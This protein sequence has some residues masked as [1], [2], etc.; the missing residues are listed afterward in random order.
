MDRFRKWLLSGLLAGL[1]ACADLSTQFG[2]RI[3]DPG[4][5]IALGPEE[6]LVVGR[7]RILENGRSKLPYSWGKPIWQLETLGVPDTPHRYLPFLSTREDGRFV[8]A[9]P[10]GRYRMAH[11]APFYYQPLIDPA[12]AF[13]GPTPGHVYYLGELVLDLDTTS[14]LGGLWGN[15][16]LKINYLEV[17]DLP[18]DLRGA[19]PTTLVME[20][21]L[22]TRLPGQL[23]ALMENGGGLLGSMRF[24]R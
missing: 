24:H 20:P 15:Y 7:I 2:A 16:I 22:L 8:Y 10:A 14:W 4:Q 6:I 23:P 18:G 21:A 5:P 13:A 17:L 9:I 11:V 3:I 19:L 12:L 1:A